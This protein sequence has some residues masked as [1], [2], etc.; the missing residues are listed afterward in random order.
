MNRF[1][2]SFYLSPNRIF[3]ELVSRVVNYF[4]MAHSLRRERVGW[5]VRRRKLPVGESTFA[6]RSDSDGRLHQTIA[7][8]TT[9]EIRYLS[10]QFNI[11]GGTCRHINVVR[12][13]PNRSIFKFEHVVDSMF[14]GSLSRRNLIKHVGGASAI[15]LGGC[16]RMTDELTQPNTDRSSTPTEHH[17]KSPAPCTGSSRTAT[18]LEKQRRQISTNEQSWTVL[19]GEWEFGPDYLQQQSNDNNRVV[20][21]NSPSLTNGEFSADI[22][23]LDGLLGQHLIW[24]ADGEF[25]SN[26]YYFGVIL[27]RGHSP[28]NFVKWGQFDSGTPVIGQRL[29]FEDTPVSVSK[30]ETHTYRVRFV[31]GTHQMWIDDHLLLTISDDA[32]RTGSLGFHCGSQTRF[33]NIQW[34]EL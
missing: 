8:E 16:L 24:R 3:W 27:N 17:S 18:P 32:H 19:T 1:L 25:K 30:G 14:D 2:L 22:T 23:S 28:K 34:R 4:D 21:A 29:S 26:Y 10:R 20:V 11:T 7:V 31:D 9:A 15:S 5:K 13:L 12:P 6:L 33:Q